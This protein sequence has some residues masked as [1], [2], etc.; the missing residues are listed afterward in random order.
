MA[1][2]T[3]RTSTTASTRRTVR[4]PIVQVELISGRIEASVWSSWFSGAVIDLYSLEGNVKLLYGSSTI[5]SCGWGVEKVSM[6]SRAG[7][8]GF[9]FSGGGGSVYRWGTAVERGCGFTAATS[10]LPGRSSFYLDASSTQIRI[11]STRYFGRASAP[12]Y[13]IESSAIIVDS[14]RTWVADGYLGSTTLWR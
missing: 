12:W 11:T 6:T 7:W 3:V 8:G 4:R 5:A 9:D 1:W 13:P 14:G 2:S 10:F